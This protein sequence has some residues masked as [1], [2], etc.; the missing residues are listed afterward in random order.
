MEISILFKERLLGREKVERFI[1]YLSKS[2]KYDIK[3]HFTDDFESLDD[4]PH[5]TRLIGVGG[6]M[7]ERF[8]AQ[9]IQTK[10]SDF[11]DF[12]FELERNVK[13]EEE[14][15]YDAITMRFKSQI[16]GRENK[17]KME[18]SQL[19]KSIQDYLNKS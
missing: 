17:I 10:L 14:I 2:T 8:N 11:I 6:I 5:M 9:R 12:Y 3:Y 4:S 19:E 15:A 7:S 1:E 13:G 18:I 16:N